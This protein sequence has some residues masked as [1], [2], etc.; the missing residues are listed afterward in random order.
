[1]KK[2]S[3]SNC[4]ADRRFAPPIFLLIFSCW[5]GAYDGGYAGPSAIRCSAALPCR[6]AILGHGRLPPIGR[7]R[8]AA[9][10]EAGDGAK[11]I[12]LPKLDHPR[13]GLSHAKWQALSP[14]EKLE[15]LFGLSLD[16]MADILSWPSGEFDPAR[17]NAQATV[18]RAVA[19]I[20]NRA[21]LLKKRR[22]ESEWERNAR[23]DLAGRLGANDPAATARA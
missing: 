18:A 1:M 4:V 2:I 15:R 8:K 9:V 7:A 10:R 16:R 20:G 14:G 21:G 3:Y 5:I 11:V 12:V 6:C 22:Q 13:A 23:E 19:M 17:L